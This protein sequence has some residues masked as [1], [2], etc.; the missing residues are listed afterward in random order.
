[1]RNQTKL[2]RF[3]QD[4]IPFNTRNKAFYGGFFWKIW[5]DVGLLGWYDIGLGL[6]G[7]ELDWNV[8]FGHA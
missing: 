4:A 7:L 1:M 5:L 3:P 6:G 2:V 8:S